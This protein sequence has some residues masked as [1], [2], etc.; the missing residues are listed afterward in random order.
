MKKLTLFLVSVGLVAL[1]GLTAC[2]PAPSLPPNAVL[3]V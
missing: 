2:A 1:L 3:S